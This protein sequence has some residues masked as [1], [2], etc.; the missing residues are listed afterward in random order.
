MIKLFRRKNLITERTEET[1]I[2]DQQSLIIVHVDGGDFR[3]S[4]SSMSSHVNAFANITCTIATKIRQHNIV[5]TTSIFYT[6]HENIAHIDSRTTNRIFL[7]RWNPLHPQSCCLRSC[8]PSNHDHKSRGFCF[9]PPPHPRS[10]RS[11]AADSES[12]QV[13]RLVARPPRPPL[14]YYVYVGSS[15]ARPPSSTTKFPSNIR[16]KQERKQ[17]PCYPASELRW[18]ANT[19]ICPTR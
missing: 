19:D 8:R 6:A 15:A 17:D 18:C 10:P 2:C 3:R 14:R 13:I 4:L 9:P 16:P 1:D 12:V 7:K 11:T 5:P